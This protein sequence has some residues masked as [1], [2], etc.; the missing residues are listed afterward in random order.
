MLSVIIPAY[1]EAQMIPITVK[2]IKGIL[3]ENCIDNELIFVDDGSKDDTWRHIEYAASSYAKVRGIRFS[4]NFGKEAAMMAGLSAAGGGANV[5]IDCDLQHPPTK[6]V[7]MYRLWEQGYEIIE[8]R[9]KSRG[10]ES[11][12][13][14]W[15]AN[16]FY[17]ICSKAVGIDM[18][19]A[20]DFKM[21]DR[22]AVNALLNIREKNVFFR[23]LSSWIGF[24]TT[25]IEFDV[26]EREAGESKW[27]TKSLFKYAISNITS[28][29]TL[30]MQLVTVC[31]LIIF[32]ISVVLG[33][34][35]IVQKISGVSADGFTTVILLLMIFSSLIMFSLGII[36]YYVAKIYEEVKGRPR[37]LIQATCGMTNT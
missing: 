1:N 21:L 12:L 25:F 35:A 5:L 3:D 6:I 23:A 11:R 32:C 36:G 34:V 14:K 27:S 13:H 30:P 7:D 17:A 31:G 28:F 37:Y 15:A 4:R 22:K 16:S 20:S 18:A 8:G 24:K 9:K 10:N 33:G 2:T 19:N 26:L 29:S